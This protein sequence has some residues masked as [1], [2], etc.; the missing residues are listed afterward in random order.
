VHRG[1]VCHDRFQ[2]LHD[3]HQ[4]SLM[5]GKARYEHLVVGI[6]NPDPMLAPEDEADPTPS[7]LSANPLFTSND[8]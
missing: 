5:A 3:D 6:P 2:V 8:I 7:A 4:K 1:G